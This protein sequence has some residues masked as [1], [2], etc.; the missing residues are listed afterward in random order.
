MANDLARQQ[1]SWGS[2]LNSPGAQAWLKEIKRQKVGEHTAVTY[3]LFASGLPKDQAYSLVLWELNEEIRT[4]LQGVTLD[5]SGRA[6]CAG[7]PDTC[8][9]PGKPNDPIDLVVLAARG[10]P[11]RF[12]LVSDDLQWK[13][14]ASVVAFPIV[15]GDQ[16]C[17]LEALLMLRD[18]EGVILKGTGFPP[19]ANIQFEGDSEG[20]VQ[21][22]SLTVSPEGEVVSAILPYKKGLHRGT[23]KITFRAKACSPAVTLPWGKNAYRWE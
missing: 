18:A 13:A 8:G 7:R 19:N 23:I 21:S 14:Y 4:A 12:G 10:E 15:A 6:M 17:S 1:L 5:E 2:K 20:E 3:Q 9:T 11:K 16:G 22:G